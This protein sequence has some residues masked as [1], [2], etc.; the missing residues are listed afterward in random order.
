MASDLDFKALRLAIARIPA[1]VSHDA[2][3]LAR[4]TVGEVFAPETHAAAL[5]PSTPIV[6]GARGAGKSFWSGVLLHEDVRKVAH[7]AYPR[8]G[9][10]RLVVRHGYTGISGPEG[11]IDREKLDDCIGAAAGPDEARAFWWATILNALKSSETLAPSRVKDHFAVARNL[12]KREAVLAAEEKRLLGDGQT[13]LIVNDA[14][15][16]VA[17][18]WPRRILLTEALLEVTWAMRAYRAIRVKLFLR[19]DQLEDDALRFV[20]LPKQRSGAVRLEWT[21]SDLYGLLFSRLALGEA[22]DALEGVLD[23]LRLQLGTPDEINKR[24]W[25][26]AYDSK[27]QAKLIGALS[28]PYMGGVKKGNTYDWPFVHLGD[29]FRQVTPR[30]FLGLMV[31]AANHGVAPTKRALTP[32]GIRHGLRAASKTRVDQLHQE[33]HWI[34][35]VL[36]PLDGLLLPQP[37]KQ[38]FRVWKQ[39]GTVEESLKDAKAKGYLPPFPTNPAA[40]QLGSEKDLYL[41][42][43]RIGVMMRRSDGRIDMPDLFRIAAK[44]LKKGATAPL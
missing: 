36:A 1:D 27:S 22:S 7:R 23:S 12:Q 18:E 38:V 40:G 9:L 33:F 26:L 13:L 4:P 5:D 37:E 43:E 41:A 42:M 6:Q 3:G 32:D 14:L 11:G 29:S 10:D 31:S 24:S 19:P 30:S 35:G 21:Q 8:I 15:D 20:E 25:P 16:T 28:G 2:I 17:V 34:K 39:A 44:L